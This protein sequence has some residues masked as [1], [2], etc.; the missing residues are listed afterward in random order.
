MPCTSSFPNIFTAT[1]VPRA[2]VCLQVYTYT[3]LFFP[4]TPEAGGPFKVA[5]LRNNKREINVNNVSLLHL[6]QFAGPAVVCWLPVFVVLSVLN[7]LHYLQ[8][9]CFP[10]ELCLGS[11]L[12]ASG[13]QLAEVCITLQNGKCFGP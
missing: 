5:I 1:T 2:S 8:K 7:S 11:L 4:S 6:E 12:L 9:V 13:Q 3:P 10:Q